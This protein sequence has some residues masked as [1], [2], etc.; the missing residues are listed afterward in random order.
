MLLHNRGRNC[1]LLSS[2]NFIIDQNINKEKI[3][4]TLNVENGNVKKQTFQIQDIEEITITF[5]DDVLLLSGTN[6]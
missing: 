5:S 4:N 6:V 2:F 1:K 3:N